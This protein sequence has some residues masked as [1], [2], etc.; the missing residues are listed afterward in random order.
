M[1]QL[2][3]EI[4]YFLYL[5]ARNSKQNIALLQHATKK[6]M[7][8]LKNLAKKVLKGI[9][10]IPQKLF[11]KLKKSK[12]FIRALASGKATVKNLKKNYQTI[13]LLVKGFLT[14]DAHPAHSKTGPSSSGGVGK[15]ARENIKR[16]NADSQSNASDWS[17]TSNNSINTDES[18]DS[19]N[20]ISSESSESEDD[21][22]LD[23]YDGI[24]DSFNNV[25]GS[26]A[27][28]SEEKTGGSQEGEVSEVSP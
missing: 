17:G 3:D 15:V 21:D 23:S 2:K 27:A 5:L 9:I 22:T 28:A 26:G 14:N 24:V 8:F 11:N 20:G 1:A 25:K 16:K 7:S 10:D 18:S 6:Q 12:L 19:D 4:R 13:R